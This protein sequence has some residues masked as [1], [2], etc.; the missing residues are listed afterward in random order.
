MHLQEHDRRFD[1]P[2]DERLRR[3]GRIGRHLAPVDDLSLCCW[4][5]SPTPRAV[6]SITWPMSFPFPIYQMSAGITTSATSMPATDPRRT[7]AMA[8]MQMRT[9]TRAI[10]ATAMPKAA[11][12]AR[13]N[14]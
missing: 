12:L 6:R 13:C 11:D 9:T 4:E 5:D 8:V 2:P 1:E 14:T 7:R 3:F 10:T